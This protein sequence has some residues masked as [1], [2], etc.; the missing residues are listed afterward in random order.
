MTQV[1]KGVMLAIIEFIN[2]FYTWG[3][4]LTIFGSQL[5]L[6]LEIGL[7]FDFVYYLVLNIPARGDMAVYKE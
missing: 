6:L 4:G 3:T 1:S 5:Y 7:V 2:S